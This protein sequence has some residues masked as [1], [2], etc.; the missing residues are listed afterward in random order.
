[1][2]FEYFLKGCFAGICGITASHPLDTIKVCIQENKKFIPS[3]AYAGFS[4]PLLGVAIEKQ[5]YKNGNCWKYI[6]IMRIHR[7][8]AHR[9]I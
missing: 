3:K 5:I 1:M 7:C 4:A 2:E 9:K 6:R 8:N